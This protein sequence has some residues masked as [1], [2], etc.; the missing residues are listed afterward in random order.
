MWRSNLYL[1][2]DGNLARISVP[3][4]GHIG[5]QHDISPSERALWVSHDD[6]AATEP[7]RKHR[8]L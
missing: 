7:V 6:D 4:D 3:C 5:R 1:S 8:C 2:A